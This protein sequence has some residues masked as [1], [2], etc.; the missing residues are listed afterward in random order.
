MDLLA[1]QCQRNLKSC[2]CYCRRMSDLCSILPFRLSALAILL[3]TILS[4]I[5]VEITTSKHSPSASSNKH[6]IGDL[7]D[8]V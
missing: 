6:E 8:L 4:S 3:G 7:G 5:R 2:H 1:F